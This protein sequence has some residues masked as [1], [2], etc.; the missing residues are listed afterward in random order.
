MEHQ[1]QINNILQQ[2]E[3]DPPGLN[4]GEPSKHW[5]YEIIEIAVLGKNDE[6]LKRL[7]KIFDIENFDFNRLDFPINHM[8]FTSPQFKLADNFKDKNKYKR[9]K[10]RFHV[11][12]E[13]IKDEVWSFLKIV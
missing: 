3:N 6:F 4:K 1:R 2:R 9:L 7:K 12:L 13:K 10:I 5:C 8:L 11:I